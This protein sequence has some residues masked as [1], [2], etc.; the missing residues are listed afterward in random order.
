MGTVHK[1]MKKSVQAHDREKLV[2]YVGEEDITP[3]TLLGVALAPY[4]FNL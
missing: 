4:I 1:P 3:V 2:S